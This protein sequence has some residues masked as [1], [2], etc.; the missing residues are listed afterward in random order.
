[1]VDMDEEFLEYELDWF[2][3]SHEGCLAYFSTAT[4]GPIPERIRTSVENYNFIFIIFTHSKSYKWLRLLRMV[5][6]YFQ[7]ERNVLVIFVYM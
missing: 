7:V 1:M 4:Q 2:L 3:S 6:L 5:F